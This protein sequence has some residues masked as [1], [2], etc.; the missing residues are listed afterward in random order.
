MKYHGFRTDV[1][2]SV[3]CAIIFI[4]TMPVSAQIPRTMSYQGVLTQS[5][6]TAVP[7]GNY[8]LTFRLYSADSGAVALWTETQN[9]A[10][11]KGIFNVILGTT[12]PITL[13][14]DRQ[15]WLGITIGSGSELTPRIQ[16][17]S[18]PYSMH[19][20]YAD[21]IAGAA[22]G[23]LR[24]TYPN[25]TIANNIVTSNMIAGGQVVKSINSLRDSVTLA[26]GSNV[27]I[28]PSGDTLTISAAGGGGGGGTITGV[29]AG[30]GL[31]GG[32]SSGNVTLSATVPFA[33]SSSYPETI[34]GTNS[35]SGAAVYGNNTTSGNYGDLGDNLAGVYG[36]SSNKGVYG[37]SSTGYGVEGSS[38][39]VGVYGTYTGSGN[40]GILGD[41]SEAVLG[42][43]YGSSYGVNGESPNGTG[44]VG[45]NTTNGNLGELG[46]SGDGVYGYSSSGNGIA[47]TSST[48]YAGYF[49]GNVYIAGNYT[50]TGS[51]T[52][53]V[54]LANGSPV[55]LFCEE[56]TGVYFVDYGEGQLVNGSAH[57]PL[58]PTFLQTVTIDAQ[59]PLMVFVQ[60]EGDCK[61][62]YVTNKT[63]TSFDV[64]ELQGGTSQVSFSYRVV[65]SR[66]YYSGLRMPTPAQDDAATRNMMEKEWPE[67]I[68]KEQ[69]MAAKMK[70]MEAQQKAMQAKMNLGSQR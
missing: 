3:F 16:L 30:T 36:N 35:G 67:V 15:Y 25:P 58:D 69:Q 44:V 40:Y 28:M 56:A 21:S 14:F 1:F 45:G 53:E 29:T 22:G 23:D 62:A 12:N 43:A 70:T 11:V 19:A 20:A 6:G 32:G 34:N 55:R 9:V 5:N 26:A 54:K 50:A 31:T 2:L 68:A 61:G 27:T 57:I 48:G 60:V 59:H 24:G 41:R 64:R 4:G 46:T 47:G 52:A 33:L 38:G 51:K 13:P 8:G 39:Y 65:C 17:T 63:A 18:S 37:S 7:E 66:K 10:V 42:W 49:S